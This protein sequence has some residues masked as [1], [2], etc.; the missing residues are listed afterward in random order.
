MQFKE[1]DYKSFKFT[2]KIEKSE[3][4]LEILEIDSKTYDDL[5]LTYLDEYN[6]FN[7]EN[8]L[9]DS[10]KDTVDKIKL[11]MTYIN[12]NN[13]M[14]EPKDADYYKYY[15]DT[16]NSTIS[17]IVNNNFNSFLWCVILFK[18]ILL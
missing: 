11:E 18:S 10:Y 7:Y 13:Q 14:V 3:L 4:K 15:V 16:N 1:S 2:I 17:P 12:S 9:Y 6:N 5:K 8:L